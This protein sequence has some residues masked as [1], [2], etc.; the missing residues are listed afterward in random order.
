MLFIDTTHIVRIDGEVP[1]L[2]LEVLPA[3]APGVLV[4]VHDVQ[5]PYNV[6]IDPGAYLTD[7]RWPMLFDEAML[8][9]AHLCSN[10]AVELVMSTPLL[11]HYREETLRRLIPGYQSLDPNDFDTH[12]GSIWWRTVEAPKAKQVR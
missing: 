4:H 12:H 9:Q 6:P 5:F 11:R 8:V 2:V 10:A 7:R 1:H 3:L